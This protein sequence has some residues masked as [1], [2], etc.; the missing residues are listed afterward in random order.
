MAKLGILL[1]DPKSLRI[2]RPDDPVAMVVVQTT[3]VNPPRAAGTRSLA[4]QIR[5]AHPEAEII[6]YVWHLISHGP[7]DGLRELGSRSLPGESDA[8][9]LL[10]DT[11]EVQAAWD[12]TLTCA[13]NLGATRMILRTPPSL[14]PGTRD[15]ARLEAWLEN[16]LK[17]S[18]MGLIWEPEGLCEPKQIA[19][20]CK[21]H[22]IE[23]MASAFYV[24]G[25]LRD[26]SLYAHWLRVDGGGA[27]HRMSP[28]HAESLLFTLD[29]RDDRD[30]K[31]IVFGGPR[32]HGNLR[33][34][35][36]SIDAE[37]F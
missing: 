25:R 24:T 12:I 16:Q 4:E 17:P 15:R 20:V 36:R 1:Q 3:L 19:A 23:A 28:A 13:R 21:K 8:F 31:T 9:G 26:E 7:R 5:K 22:G 11:P 27:L 30:D 34:Y 18:G 29:E 14:S 6:P 2:A 10:Q 32:G 35:Q 33:Q 37:G